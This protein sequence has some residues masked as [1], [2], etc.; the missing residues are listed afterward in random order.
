[1]WIECWLSPQRMSSVRSRRFGLEESAKRRI[2]WWMLTE[3]E[4]WRQRPG[5][6]SLVPLDPPGLAWCLNQRVLLLT[7]AQTAAGVFQALVGLVVQLNSSR[8]ERFER[9]RRSAGESMGFQVDWKNM[10][11]LLAK[12]TPEASESTNY[13]LDFLI[14]GRTA[15]WCRRGRW[16]TRRRRRG[17]LRGGLSKSYL[18]IK[19]IYIQCV[20][21]SEIV[22]GA[23]SRRS[24]RGR[25]GRS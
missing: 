19:I 11:D 9:Q 2:C 7:W 13:L 25:R 6:C 14:E 8:S 4:K 10:R 15:R 3:V 1:M 23:L 16:N 5:G 12:G 17:S 22:S 20:H 18:V 21:G 24:W